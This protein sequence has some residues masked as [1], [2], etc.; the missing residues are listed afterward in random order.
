MEEKVMRKKWRAILLGI[1]LTVSQVSF[2]AE[3]SRSDILKQVIEKAKTQ[4]NVSQELTQFDYVEMA[5]IY[6]LI[7]R[8]EADRTSI[9]IECEADGDILSY[10]YNAQVEENDSTL[11]DYQTAKANARAFIKQVASAY[12][13]ELVIDAENLP[14]KGNT[15][16]FTYHRV[17]N[18]IKVLGQTV[19]VEVSKRTGKVMNFRGISYDSEAKFDSPQPKVSMDKAQQSYLNEL[20]ITLSYKTYHDERDK[21]QSYLV[22]KVD[23]NKRKGI[24]ASSGKVV[25]L[26]F[27]NENIAFATGAL[28]ENGAAKME[29]GYELTESEKKAVAQRKDFMEES[30]IQSICAAYFPVIESMKITSSTIRKEGDHFIRFLNMERSSFSDEKAVDFAYLQVDAVTG[31]VLGYYYNGYDNGENEIQ[32]LSSSEKWDEADAKAFLKKIAPNEADK[33]QL[34][35]KKSDDIVISRSS[36]ASKDTL[37]KTQ[38]FDFVRTYSNI[39]VE[40]NGMGLTYDTELKQVVNY[41]KSWDVINFVSPTGILSKEEAIKHIGLELFYMQTG[42]HQYTLVYNHEE[43]Y[44][45]LGAFSGKKVNYRGE[46]IK[47]EVG[48]LYKDIKGHPYETIITNL[49]YSGIYLEGQS[50]KPDTPITQEEM[51][52]LLMRAATYFTDS[53]PYDIAKQ[54]KWLSEDEVNPNQKITKEEGVKLLV[55]ATPYGKIAGVNGIFQY[56]YQDQDVSEALKGYIAVAYGMELLPHTEKWMPKSD[57]SKAEAMLYLYKALDSHEFANF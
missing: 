19:T 4:I 37:E 18:G 52:T 16:E 31:E 53:E 14:T 43:P 32:L 5:D 23:N 39:P 33:V 2:G 38:Y 21:V 40:F 49:Y 47:E 30:K 44:M 3:T 22:Y 55:K 15:Y 42:E 45:T 28:A 8:D 51:L 48:G 25:D 46:E 50:L 9:Y 57:L 34:G 12:E 36:V 27:M 56:P 11:V 41:R 54:R 17:H 29:V 20:G 24:S 7:W 26:W 1:I 13:K 6:Q 10:R 35:T